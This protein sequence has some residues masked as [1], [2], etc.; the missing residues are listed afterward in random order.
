MFSRKKLREQRGQASLFMALFAATLILLFAF[1]TN[2]GMLVHAKINLQNAADAAAY[3]GAA[4]Q[5]RQLTAVGY[6]NWEMRRALK[7]FL[8]YYTIRSQYASM[9][10]YPLDVTAHKLPSCTARFGPV[11]PEQRHDF[12]FQDPRENT[13]ETGGPYIPT[14]CIIFNRDNNYCQKNSVAGIPEFRGSGSFGVAD[15]IVAAVKNAT[16]QII[17]KKINDCLGRSDINRQFL[18]AWLFNLDP[19]PILLTVGQDSADPFPFA[20]GLERVGVLPRLAILRARI[21]NFE[22]ELNMN[23]ANEGVGSVT[24]TEASMGAIKNAAGGNK[25]LDYF[26]RP[27][28][29][30]LSAKN[31]LPSVGKDNGIFGNVELTELIPNRTNVDANAN[32]RNPPALVKFDDIVAKATFANSAFTTLDITGLDR[33]NCR[34]FRELRTIPHFPFGVTKNPEVLTYYAVRLQA[35]ARLLF[36]PFGGNGVVTL[37]A[38]SAAKPFGSRVGRNLD[39]EPSSIFKPMILARGLTGRAIIDGH[40]SDE[41]T[42][43]GS[44]TSRFP[45]VLVSDGDNDAETGGFT[46]AGHLGYIRHAMDLFN[47]ADYGPRLAG[48]YAPWEVGYYTVPANYQTPESI[49]LFEDNPAYSGKFFALRAPLFPVNQNVHDMSF[50][51]ERVLQYL[52][53]GVTEAQTLRGNFAPVLNAYM[54]DP[55][56][57]ALYAYLNNMGNQDR[58]HYIPDPLLNDEPN[59]IS[60]A[61]Q[62]GPRYTVA[63]MTN[64]QRRQLTSWNNQKTSADR[65]LGIAANSELGPDIGRSGYSVRFVSFNAL[66][67]GGKATND[68]NIN[69][70]WSDPFRRFDAGDAGTRIMEDIDKIQH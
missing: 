51:R 23:L 68:P 18:G 49:G 64:S 22:E 44:F 32:L 8:Y 39:P 27:I 61:I 70:E 57:A 46:R 4:V 59:L 3:A 1:T 47:R 42:L 65:D 66:R 52:A 53:G 15:P 30:Y 62:Y 43:T 63:G 31:N 12:A 55:Q 13:S 60:Y 5:A 56:W 34:Q 17:A 41:D 58:I 24:L 14:V 50:L 6:L 29:A 48:A 36:S 7:E 19:N 45:N 35:K 25:S 26:E 11:S 16:N 20:P 67:A 2:V 33:G 40:L 9:P 37:S 21:D 28:Q 38:Y 54:S 69:A 10:C